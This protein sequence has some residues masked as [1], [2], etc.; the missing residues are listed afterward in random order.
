MD[1]K[2]Q[3]IRTKTSRKPKKARKK[4]IGLVFKYNN[5]NIEEKFEFEQEETEYRS[6]R[7]ILVRNFRPEDI[8]EFIASKLNISE[9]KFY[10]KNRRELVEAKAI[11][12]LLMRSLCN[13]K[14][15]DICSVLGN[16]SQVRVSELS[17]IGI[18]LMD[19]K[20]Y[21]DIMEEFIKCYSA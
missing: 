20:K 3:P 7:K 12:V 8:I 19:N 2:H 9:L 14:C 15:T 6:G 13:Y 5:E 10:I 21:K 17:N 16:L 11:I 4:Y 18:K 1:G